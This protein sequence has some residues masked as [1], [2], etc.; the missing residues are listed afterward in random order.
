LE[1]DNWI[2]L[3]LLFVKDTRLF[4]SRVHPIKNRKLVFYSNLFQNK[5]TLSAITQAGLVNNLN[6][7]MIWGLLPIVLLIYE[8]RFPKYWNYSRHLSHRMGLRSIIYRK[9]VRYLFEKKM[10]F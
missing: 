10:L 7:G 4:C 3:T 1:F 8:L 6:D 2:L 5:K 9:N